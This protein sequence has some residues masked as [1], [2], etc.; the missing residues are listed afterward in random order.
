MP[1]QFPQR[2]LP[3]RRIVPNRLE[4]HP[5]Q[6]Q[7]ARLQTGIV[8]PHAIP[9]DHRSMR[10]S[11]MRRPPHEGHQPH[12]LQENPTTRSMPHDPQWTRK[13][14]RDRTPH[15]RKPRNFPFDE[16]R[17]FVFGGSLLGQKRF[18]LRSHDAVQER[19]FRRS[20]FVRRRD[21]RH[22]AAIA[23]R[24]PLSFVRYLQLIARTQKKVAEKADNVSGISATSSIRFLTVN[25]AGFTDPFQFLVSR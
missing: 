6:R 17:H 4:I 13:N 5:I 8:A 15:S 24:T 9:V 7:A 2:L 20:D 1:A 18:Q 14:P 12:F 3:H 25:A 23:S 10:I 22:A 16:A 21:S 19:L 11:A